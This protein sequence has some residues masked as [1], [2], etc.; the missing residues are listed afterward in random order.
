MESGSTRLRTLRDRNIIA[1]NP[2]TYGAFLSRLDAA[3]NPN[4]RLRQTAKRVERLLGSQLM[5]LLAQ[6]DV[7]SFNCGV[8][9]LDDWLKRQ[10]RVDAVS[11][12]PWTF[13]LRDRGKVIGYYV[14]APGLVEV[15]GAGANAKN[16]GRATS[17]MILSRLAIDRAQQG[18]GLSRALMRDLLER[19]VRAEHTGGTRAV[20]VQATS[21]GEKEFLLSLGFELSGLGPTTLIMTVADAKA[22][23]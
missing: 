6:D 3:P 5:L 15:I 11:T 22:A 20:L 10:M 18:K 17:V 4:D 14:L 2:S 8:K 16:N 7:A 19:A 23:I 9:S 21:A 13:V 1:V 12:P